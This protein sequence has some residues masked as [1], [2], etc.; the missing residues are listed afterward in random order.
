MNTDKLTEAI[1]ALIAQK[2]FQELTSS[3][4]D[5]ICSIMEKADYDELHLAMQVVSEHNAAT[6]GR[7][8]ARVKANVMSAWDSKHPTRLLI[9]GWN[10]WRAAAVLFFL[11]SAVLFF[12]R[13]RSINTTISATTTT[14]TVYVERTIPVLVHDTVVMNSPVQVYQTADVPSSNPPKKVAS[15]PLVKVPIDLSGDVYVG[16]AQDMDASWNQS[17]RIAPDKDS[18]VSKFGFVSL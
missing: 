14:D 17:R 10:G 11:L 3:E 13:D 15:L 8:M 9:S 16:G 4:R 7:G 12:M 6:S 1:W 2:S 5:H 18:L